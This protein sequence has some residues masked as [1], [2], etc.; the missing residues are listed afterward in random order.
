MAK[1]G[2]KIP[3]FI[4]IEFQRMQSRQCRCPGTDTI[5]AVAQRIDGIGNAIDYATELA[6]IHRV[7]AL[8]PG[9]TS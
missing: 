8:V 3:F 9:A 1:S 4:G 5:H 2:C 7:V 6:H